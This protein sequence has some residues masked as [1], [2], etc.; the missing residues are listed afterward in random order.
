[1]ADW[2]KRIT[3]VLLKTTIGNIVKK[4]SLKARSNG[5]CSMKL[6]GHYLEEG[7]AER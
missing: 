3:D 4:I 1:M 5:K 7:R 2:V 6:W